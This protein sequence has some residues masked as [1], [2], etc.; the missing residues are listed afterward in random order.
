MQR[1]R[2][3]DYRIEGDKIRIRFDEAEGL[4]VRDGRVLRGF[5][6]CRADRRFHW[7]EAAI[8]RMRRGGRLARG[9]VSFGRSL[10]LGRQSGLQSDQCFR[11]AC[12]AVPDRPLA[13]NH[14]RQEIIRHIL[15]R[16]TRNLYRQ[17]RFF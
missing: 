5:A 11:T 4:A 14:D 9:P 15:G 2:V 12:L 13:G 8:D 1:S 7:A 16:N 17:G 3:P 6:V 10:R